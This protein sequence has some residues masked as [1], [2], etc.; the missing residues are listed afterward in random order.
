MDEQ[1]PSVLDNL[2]YWMDRATEFRMDR[3]T[4]I[5]A[6]QYET[7][8]KWVVYQSGYILNKQGEFEWEPLPS[9]RSDGFLDNTRFASPKE[10]MIAYMQYLKTASKAKEDKPVGS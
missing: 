8:R 7:H 4:L 6:R 2:Q 5:Q 9:E 10:A 1:A 3:Y